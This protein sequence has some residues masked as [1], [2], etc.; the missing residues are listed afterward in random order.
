MVEPIRFPCKTKI[1]QSRSQKNDSTEVV[2][3]VIIA[4]SNIT[5]QKNDD[6]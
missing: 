4:Y 2:N 1:D 3:V 5:Q 6:F